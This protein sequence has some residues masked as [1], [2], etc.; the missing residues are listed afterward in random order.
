MLLRNKVY[1][2]NPESCSFEEARFSWNR[3]FLRT[4]L[5]AGIVVFVG[6]LSYSIFPYLFDE[7]KA[8]HSR[9]ESEVLDS[10]MSVLREKI[11]IYERQV[12]ELLMRDNRIYLPIVGEKEISKST[13]LAPKGG[14]AKNKYELPQVRE[15]RDRIDRLH[16]RIKI[17]G[18]SYSNVIT[19]ASNKEEEIRNIPS[20]LPVNAVMISG[21][22]FRTHPITGV[23]KHHDGIDFACQTGTPIYASGRGI[24]ED[25]TYNENGYG[26]CINIDH[27]N[28]YRSKYAHLSKMLVKEGKM[29]DRGELIGY[30]GSTGLSS[31]PHLHYEISFENVKI[32]PI[33][34]FYQDL[35]PTH[36]R[37]LVAQAEAANPVEITIDN[38]KNML[39]DNTPMD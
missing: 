32:D 7:A 36:Y 26:I 18:L 8:A 28:G 27:G 24:V 4:V 35:S 12:N 30:S 38:I 17:L 23:Q 16:F 31:G 20:I 2:Y 29:V 5:L 15:M 11:D 25:A 37:N 39:I 33:D 19:K 21:F 14:A 22:G 34:F 6:F 1:Y 13:W 9:L 3:F 10:K